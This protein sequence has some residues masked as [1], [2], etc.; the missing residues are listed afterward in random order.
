MKLYVHYSVFLASALLLGGCAAPDGS[1]KASTA[2][3][4]TSV[5]SSLNNA[6]AWY[7]NPPI[8]KDEIFV[9]G[10]ETSA[11]MQMAMDKAVYAAKRSLVE[12]IAGYISTMT[13]QIAKEVNVDGKNNLVTSLAVATKIATENVN[14]GGFNKEASKIVAEG[15]LYRAYVLIS[16][17]KEEAN[18]ALLTQIK[19]QQ[20]LNNALRNSKSFNAL[21]SALPQ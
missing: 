12:Q 17:P 3:K 18:R 4:E 13:R 7:A 21:E 11:N 9:S 15:S 16:L 5:K 6:P 1:S 14:I 2:K 8:T 20:D 19:R 10:S